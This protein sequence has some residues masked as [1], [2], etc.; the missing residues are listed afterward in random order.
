MGP[1]L[2]RP[3]TAFHSVLPGVCGGV[4]RACAC[5]TACTPGGWPSSCNCCRPPCTRALSH[6]VALGARGACKLPTM[7]GMRPCHARRLRKK[8]LRELA[9]PAFGT[10]QLTKFTE[11]A[12]IWYT[13]VLLQCRLV[14]F[15][16]RPRTVHNSESARAPSQVSRSAAARVSAPI[17]RAWRLAQAGSG[18][19][20]HSQ[21]FGQDVARASPTVRAA[22]V[23]TVSTKPI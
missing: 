13:L 15:C 23:L 19:D 6:C 2:P 9:E 21:G 7:Q 10:L 12:N 4:V 20:S 17:L 3:S 8:L 18:P 11:A 16:S 22:S 5:S 14:C 1:C